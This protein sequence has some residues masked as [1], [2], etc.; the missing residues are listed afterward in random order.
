VENFHAE[1]ITTSYYLTSVFCGG[2]PAAENDDWLSHN[3]LER[4]RAFL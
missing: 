3:G 4:A 1:I 2:V